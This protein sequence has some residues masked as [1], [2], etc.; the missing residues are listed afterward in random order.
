MQTPKNKFCGGS[1]RKLPRF[2]KVAN[3]NRL[4]TPVADREP[5]LSGPAT[6]V[7]VTACFLHSQTQ[8]HG[9]KCQQM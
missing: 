4:E 6:A 3:Q 5:L 1:I 7:C 9:S 2:L 8:T